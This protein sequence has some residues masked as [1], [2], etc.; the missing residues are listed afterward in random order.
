MKDLLQN[1]GENYFRLDLPQQVDRAKVQKLV[2]DFK[3][4]YRDIVQES[5]D[6]SS[7]ANARVK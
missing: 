4:I 1:L 6:K 2:E 3:Q 5:S 7:E